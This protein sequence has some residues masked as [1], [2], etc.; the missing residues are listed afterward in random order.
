MVFNGLE[1]DTFRGLEEMSEGWGRFLRAWENLRAVPD[2][3]REIDERRVLVTMHNTGR[4][5]T[6]GMEVGELSQ[7]SVNLFELENGK[8]TRLIA[9]WDAEEAFRALGI[10]DPEA[11]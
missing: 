10:E 9:Y 5:R 6:S 8:V 1:R 2:L 3:F 11:E 4:G 7:R